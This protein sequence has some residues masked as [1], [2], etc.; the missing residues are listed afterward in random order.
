MLFK[1][2]SYLFLLMRMNYYNEFVQTSI[3]RHFCIHVTKFDDITK[4]KPFD[5]IVLIQRFSLLIMDQYIKLN[6][7]VFDFAF[8]IMVGPR[9]K[10]QIAPH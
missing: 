7:F 2:A 3:R 6:F 8:H 1:E 10:F 5:K 9:Q 4:R